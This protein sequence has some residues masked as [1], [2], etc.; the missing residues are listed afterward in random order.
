MYS[1]GG[2]SAV[3]P[4]AGQANELDAFKR[5]ED[6]AFANASGRL[7]PF[8]EQQKAQFAQQMANQGIP[9]GSD[10]YNKALAQMNR[11][12][13]DAM[14]GAAF[15]SMGFGLQAQNQSFGQDHA[16]SQ[17]ANALMQAQMQKDVG[18]ANVNL[19]YGRLSQD[20]RQFDQGLAE[21][22]RQFND[23]LSYDYDTF[24]DT[25]GQRNYEFDSTQDYNYWD[26]GNFYDIANRGMDTDDYRWAY[27]SGPSGQ[28]RY[29]DAYIMA[30][31]GG[32]P[33]GVAIL[34]PNNAY[35]T[36]I[37]GANANQ[38]NLMNFLTSSITA[39]KPGGF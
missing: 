1:I 27:E 18:M 10:A 5:Y 25:L 35:N 2:V 34:D 29:A 6:A 21:K 3:N 20:G 24:Y 19:G 33:P 15:D 23:A 39:A 30:L 13:S 16:R 11:S 8:I 22:A 7:N 28:Q 12:Q 32:A 37:T 36:Q 38:A 26:R 31:L 14:S 4:Q 9:A 17:L